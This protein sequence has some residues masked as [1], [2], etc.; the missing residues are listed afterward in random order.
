M[1]GYYNYLFFFLIPAVQ[2]II[3]SLFYAYFETKLRQARVLLLW[4]CS[5]ES[6]RKPVRPLHETLLLEN[7]FDVEEYG[8]D[9][10]LLCVC[11]LD[12]LNA[13]LVTHWIRTQQPQELTPVVVN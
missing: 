8:A 11:I 5:A 12:L 10:T 2:F 1:K 13:L 6:L 4:Y 3:I 7:R 9:S